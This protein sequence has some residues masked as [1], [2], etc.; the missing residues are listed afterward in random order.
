MKVEA[1]LGGYMHVCVEIKSIDVFVI[2]RMHNHLATWA[3]LM[4]PFW[5]LPILL[6]VLS[7]QQKNQLE[8]I[9]TLHISYY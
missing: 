1:G 8:K 4:V 3:T 9:F 5:L 7:S 2:V 6:L